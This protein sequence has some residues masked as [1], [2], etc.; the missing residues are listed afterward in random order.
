MKGNK[1][2]YRIGKGRRRNEKRTNL[3]SIKNYRE[4]R[5][6]ENGNTWKRN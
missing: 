6:K 3:G 1:I 2:K 5:K 4:E